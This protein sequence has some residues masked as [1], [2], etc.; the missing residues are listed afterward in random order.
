LSV[1][2]TDATPLLEA[3][4]VFRFYS[5]ARE[6]ARVAGAHESAPVLQDVTLQ[7]PKGR[8]VVVIK[9]S[10]SGKSTLLHLLCGLDEPSFG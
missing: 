7:V 3:R 9:P 8:F 1:F 4:G 2:T 10:G 5:A 6:Y